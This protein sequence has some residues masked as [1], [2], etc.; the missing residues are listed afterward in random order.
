MK[1][2]FLFYY[3]CLVLA[4]CMIIGSPSELLALD[5]NK[6]PSQYSHSNWQTDQGLPSNTIPVIYQS[7]NGYLWLGTFEGLVRFDGVQFTNFDQ[8]NFPELTNNRVL[9]ITED[10]NNILYFGTQTVGL[11]KFGEK[12]IVRVGHQR[13]FG[14]INKL[15]T[16]ASGTV[17]IGSSNGVFRLENSN[18]V[19]VMKAEQLPQGFKYSFCEGNQVL[20]IGAPDGLYKYNSGT[21]V[22]ETAFPQVAIA[23]ICNDRL[24][25]IWVAA[26]DNVVKLTKGDVQSP[27]L[28]ERFFNDPIQSLISGKDGNV[29]IATAH[30]LARFGT[31]GR[32]VKFPEDRIPDD[33]VISL[34]EDRE[35][36]LWVGTLTG[37]L[38]RFRDAAFTTI[39]D[40]DGLS[41]NYVRSII[42]T[43][44]GALW[45]ATSN[46]LTHLQ[47]N[48]YLT[49]NTRNGL[50]STNPIT[51][52]FEDREGTLW[53]GGAAGKIEK[54]SGGK[55]SD[56]S[57]GSEGNEV[58]YSFCQDHEGTLWIGTTHSLFILKNNVVTRY[59][60]A[61]GGLPNGLIATILEDKS[62]RIWASCL[63]NGV[64]CITGEKLTTY[65]MQNGLS[66]N[67]ILCMKEDAKGTLW[68]GSDG[69]GL[70]R[71]KDG[72][73]TTITTKDGLSDN[74]I[75]SITEDANGN[76]WMSYN[77]AVFRI[78][79]QEIEDVM[80]GKSKSVVSTAYGKEDGMVSAE[81][82]K[83]FSPSAWQTRSGMICFPT[84]KGMT[85]VIP[86]KM[87]RNDLP[88]P[89]V[90]EEIKVDA[91][92]FSSAESLVFP[93]GTNK[94]DFTYT[95][96]SLLVPS[97]VKFKY[98][99]IELDSTW[100]NVG[101]RRTAYYTN[102]A[103]GDYT[104]QVTASNNDGIWNETGATLHFSVKPFFYQTWW[105]KITAVVVV[106]GF[107]FLF[108]RLRLRSLLARKAELEITVKERT[109]DLSLANNSLE[110]VNKELADTVV[111]ISELN[112]NLVQLNE[113]K[114]EV[115]GIVAHDLK[116]PLAGIALTA[117]N[118][119]RYF[120]ML[121]QTEVL[122][123]ME[124][125]E[126]SAGRMR[127]IIVN[128]LD[129]NAIETGRM[130]LKVEKVDTSA[131][132][133][134]VIREFTERSTAKGIRL[135]LDV[136]PKE[137][138]ALADLTA[139]HEI[140]DNLVSNAI[141]FSSKDKSVQISVRPAQS[142]VRIEVQDEGPGIS[143][144]DKKK[145]FGRY[146]R[147]SAKPTGG[148]HSSGLGLSIVKKLVEVMGGQ[149]WCESVVGK[150]TTF[151]VELPAA[152]FMQSGT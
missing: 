56:I 127:D 65:S 117:S 81:C 148:E 53:I 22:R 91:A 1:P 85:S 112:K 51:A 30:G 14:S 123:M 152:E 68:F 139:T 54:Y 103:P 147:L 149:V 115:L 2:F 49:Y 44:D 35:G 90:I 46:G 132:A 111:E 42:E 60:T 137:I 9:A 37:G 151:I 88:P 15:F 79:K 34:F 48:I 18:P 95:G 98:R 131:L 21:L 55:F 105:F 26:S 31:N 101:T 4:G 144:E 100:A 58:A 80:D 89:V 29:W 61:G 19:Q 75:Y 128:L 64:S 102:L 113:D 116:N 124:K 141:K 32:L 93:A 50:S 83:G 140:L 6:L 77:K 38:Y 8:S 138:L 16:D 121:P 20:W 10:K 118:V 122:Q 66:S 150:G 125:I 12:K 97:G 17:W 41:G 67:S 143:D 84:V 11:Y 70:T 24:G 71:L 57:L 142:M 107:G 33:A 47:N 3:C 40:L 126:T 114:T 136:P 25:N 110:K 119:K 120:T 7:H 108:Y 133:T 135:K 74:R 43:K 73:F 5:G 129:V 59:S 36:S 63:G 92:V 78:N 76:F 28:V 62:G 52:L 106:F 13:L 87:Y 146:V 96:L 86:N 82:N 109:K 104:F 99:I 69:G 72:Q 130:N 134:N 23:G 39:T 45:I 27:L 145:L 94:I